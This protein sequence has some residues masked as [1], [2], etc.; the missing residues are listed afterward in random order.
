MHCSGRPSTHRDVRGD[1]D[2]RRSATYA[3]TTST[4]VLQASQ[5]HCRG[6]SHSTVTDSP[7][8]D[9]RN[10]FLAPSH[11]GGPSSVPGHMWP[12][13]S[14]RSSLFSPSKNLAAL[15]LPAPWASPPSGF[16][17]ARSLVQLSNQGPSAPTKAPYARFFEDRQLPPLALDVLES[18]SKNCHQYGGA[19]SGITCTNEVSGLQRMSSDVLNSTL[20]P[21]LF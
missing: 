11:H 16:T 9:S 17:A 3:P 18:G 15:T 6:V 2:A 13:E 14:T 19:T 5:Q 1:F 8:G 4:A 20:G 12:E 21:T 10:T 7:S